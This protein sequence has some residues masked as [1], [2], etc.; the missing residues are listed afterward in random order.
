MNDRG[1]SE[2]SFVDHKGFLLA[3]V[4]WTCVALFLLAGS[5]AVALDAGRMPPVTKEIAKSDTNQQPGGSQQ[6]SV[7]DDPRQRQEQESHVVPAP[8]AETVEDLIAKYSATEANLSPPQWKQIAKLLEVFPTAIEDMNKLK[9][10][11]AT[12]AGLV[13]RDNGDF[14]LKHFAELPQQA[15]D[16]WAALN[17]FWP[18][19]NTL[20]DYD[21]DF[22]RN[23][24][25]SFLTDVPSVR[26][27]KMLLD[28]L[29]RYQESQTAFFK[30]METIDRV[31]PELVK[32]GLK[33][34]TPPET[35]YAAVVGGVDKYPCLTFA[36]YIKQAGDYYRV[37]TPTTV[38][39]V[40]IT[41]GELLK[42]VTEPPLSTGKSAA[43][44]AGL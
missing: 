15:K 35:K 40:N 21:R 39:N 10:L 43:A 41:V 13:T 9:R 19:D 28:K 34:P 37:K 44:R 16:D 25:K 14:V 32:R 11:A 22:A 6:Q 1:S 24:Q 29:H 3:Y 23:L 26:D 20:D 17:G 12:R 30:C 18:F 7:T 33:L 2:F 5:L 36:E 31:L 38:P 27:V 8:V 4:L 42:Q